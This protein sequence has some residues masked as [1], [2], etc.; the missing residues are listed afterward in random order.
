MKL[1][2]G[3]IAGSRIFSPGLRPG[4]LTWLG[5]LGIQPNQTRFNRYREILG[6]VLEHRIAGTV[7]ELR[8]IVPQEQY[9]IAFIESTDLIEIAKTFG[10]SRGPRFREKIRI[11]TTG[12]AHPLDEKKVG[13]KARDILFELGVAA[14]FRN[15]KFPV[16]SCMDSLVVSKPNSNRPWDIAATKEFWESYFLLKFLVISDPRISTSIA[17]QETY[18]SMRNPAPTMRCLQRIST[19]VCAQGVSDEAWCA[20]ATITLYL[21]FRWGV[22]ALGCCPKINRKNV[23]KIPHLL[24]LFRRL[25]WDVP[26][27]KV[28][29]QD[30]LS[31]VV[32]LAEPPSRGVKSPLEMLEAIL[33]P[34]VS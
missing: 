12:P 2:N 34:S 14:F 23:E 27:S 30:I 10:R 26:F 32:F 31:L 15:R 6:T 21:C 29:P 16:L 28:H 3:I 1:N 17:K 5:A 20:A 4:T 7:D 33:N 22:P 25:L 11:A 24:R 13:L 19:G 18:A 9:R 8:T